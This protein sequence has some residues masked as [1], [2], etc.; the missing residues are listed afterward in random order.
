MRRNR[1][2]PSSDGVHVPLAAARPAAGPGKLVPSIAPL[3]ART[4]RCFS[5]LLGLPLH[6]G[7]LLPQV[8][9][10]P[11]FPS[12]SPGACALLFLQI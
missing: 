8:M 10:R 9:S 12:L 3:R 7:D 5:S 1:P 6:R 11:P 2:G 4:V